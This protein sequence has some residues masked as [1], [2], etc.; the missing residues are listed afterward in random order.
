MKDRHVLRK[1]RFWLWKVH[2]CSDEL[3][4][5]FRKIVFGCGK[6]IVCSDEFVFG[7]GKF[8]ISSGE[9]VFDCRKIVFGLPGNILEYLP[10]NF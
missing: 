1:D 4:F 8:I 10:F 3:V 9:L 7:C 5:G 2:Y 6:F